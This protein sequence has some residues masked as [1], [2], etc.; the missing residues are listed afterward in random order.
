MITRLPRMTKEEERRPSKRMKNARKPSRRWTILFYKSALNIT[1]IGR[2][3]QP[4][5]RR[6]KAW[7]TT[8]WW[9]EMKTSR[10]RR[11]GSW[12]PNF[13]KH[14]VLRANQMKL[15]CKSFVLMQSSTE[16]G[17][18]QWTRTIRRKVA[19][20]MKEKRTPKMTSSLGCT[21]SW[22]PNR[23]PW[24]SWLTTGMSSGSTASR[25]RDWVAKASRSATSRRLWYHGFASS[26]SSKTM[27]TCE[28][29]QN[30]TS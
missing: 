8:N 2:I 21:E 7:P 1:S 3:A 26:A 19:G 20:L 16:I 13:G 22:T 18:R 10:C 6:I 28:R 5:P 12:K 17:A 15:A 29:R 11:W 23:R 4:R 25:K 14:Q 9:S 24:T 27:T 30:N